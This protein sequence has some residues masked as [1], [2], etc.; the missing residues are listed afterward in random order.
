MHHV[1]LMEMI[2]VDLIDI[3]PG[4]IESG[5]RPEEKLNSYKHAQKT[6]DSTGE[7]LRE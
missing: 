3:G 2:S 5:K 6:M 7:E 4:E 1:V